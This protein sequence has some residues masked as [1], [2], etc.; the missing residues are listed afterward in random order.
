VKEKYI[1]VNFIGERD[2]VP[3]E[4]EAKSLKKHEGWKLALGGMEWNFYRKSNFNC[5]VFDSVKHPGLGMEGKYEDIRYGM[6]GVA[7]GL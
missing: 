7:S 2:T 4:E 3:T 1:T 5:F 6:N